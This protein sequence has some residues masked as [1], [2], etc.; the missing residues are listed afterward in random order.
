M[1]LLAND[2][3]LLVEAIE[4]MAFRGVLGYEKFEE[5]HQTV[6]AHSHG[7]ARQHRQVLEKYRPDLIGAIHSV[8]ECRALLYKIAS[9]APDATGTPE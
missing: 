2:E 9:A 4:S 3:Q 7:R 8:F 5:P 6:Y 1:A